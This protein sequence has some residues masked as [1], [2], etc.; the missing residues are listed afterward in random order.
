[1]FFFKIKFTGYLFFEAYSEKPIKSLLYGSKHGR[2]RTLAKM[3]PESITTLFEPPAKNPNL[4]KIGQFVRITTGLYEGDIG[5]VI[6]QQKFIVKVQIVPRVDV[7][8]LKNV[9]EKYMDK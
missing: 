2:F 7:N 1:M 8:A 3:T 9:Y 6:A 5:K 4:P